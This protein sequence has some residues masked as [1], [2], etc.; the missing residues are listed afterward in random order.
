MC[1]EFDAYPA[2]API[3]G[4]A[5]DSEDLVLASA[6][7]TKFAAFAARS[8]DN[9]GAGIVV[10]PDVRGLYKFYEELALRF[11]EQKVN[12]VAID[13][14]GRTAGVDKR[15]EEFP[16]MEH[17]MQTKQPQIAADTAA[18]VAYLRSPEGGSCSSIFTVGFCF[19]GSNSWTQ[20]T[21]GHDLKGVIGFYGRPGDGRD[22]TPGPAARAGDFKAPVLALMGGA[23]QGIPKEQVE[24]YEAALNAAGVENEI[25]VYEGAPHSFFDRAYE[26]FADTCDDAWERVL[27]FIARNS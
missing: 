24:E 17:V 23:D 20:A 14:F 10:L 13:Y 5:V 8:P 9:G 1:H 4:A 18:A 6:D 27:A 26:Q 3:R 12:A 15:G 7:G 2:V 19:G 25:V 11:A 22:G 21:A 16:F